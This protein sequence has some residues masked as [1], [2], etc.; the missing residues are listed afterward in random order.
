MSTRGCR[1]ERRAP[2][3]QPTTVGAAAIDQSRRHR[4]E[5]CRADEF[6]SPTRIHPPPDARRPL[7]QDLFA[8][9]VDLQVR[10]EPKQQ[11]E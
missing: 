9:N 6:T 4:S 5:M 7:Q 3:A 2:P 11:Q 10:I 8:M 1:R